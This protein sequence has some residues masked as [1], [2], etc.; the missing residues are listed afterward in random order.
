MRKRIFH[1]FA[2][3]LCTL[4]LCSCGQEEKNEEIKI[5]PAKYPLTKEVVDEAFAKVDLP[6]VISEEEYDSEIRTSM[7]IRDEEN[8][9]IAAIAS[10]GDGEKRFLGITWIGYL[11]AGAASVYLP[12][13][14]WEDMVGFASLLAGFEDQSIV[15]NDFTANYEQTAILTEYQY[16]AEPYYA[17]RYEWLKFYGDLT[18][19][20][21]V[22]VAT[23]GTKEISSISFFNTPEYSNKNSEMAAK[24]FLNYVFLSIPERYAKYVEATNGKYDP[25]NIDDAFL[26]SDYS[27]SYINHYKNIVTENCLQNMESAGYF[28][29]VDYLAA[30]A[31]SQVRFY[32]AVFTQADD[33]NGDKDVES[34]LYTA[35]LTNEKDGKIEEFTVQ[36]SIDAA[37]MLNGWKI[38]NFQ[39][40]DL[41]ALSMYI[42]DDSEVEFNGERKN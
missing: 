5:S 3:L 2:M 4:V 14:K 31:G 36:G 29:L 15:Y 28:T 22:S 13:E 42:T 39:I 35:T 9:L 1:L 16:D 10:N 11:R 27:V 30:K 33:V 24:T 8:K 26:E 18:C 21:E 38:S 34:Y 12:E 40:N 17:K 19:Q 20:I 6:G 23:D 32:N 7:D 25:V 37:N 41:G